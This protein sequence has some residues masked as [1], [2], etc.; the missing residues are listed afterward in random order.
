MNQNLTLISML[1]DRSGSMSAVWAPT[2]DGFNEFVSKQ[3]AEKTGEAS[4]TLIQFDDQYETHYLRLDIKDV[5]PLTTETYAPRGTTSLLDAIGRSITE[6]GKAL[7]A[8][9]EAERPGKVLFVI[10]TDGQE[11]S[12]K[13]FTRAQVFDLIKHQREKYAWDFIFLGANQDA[14]TVGH[15]MGFQGSKTMTFGYNVAG[16]QFAFDSAAAYTTRTRSFA[17]GA[18]GQ[19]MNSFTEE[20]REE[21]TKAGVDPAQNKVV[22]APTKI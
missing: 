5:R 4:M 18:V 13:E 17:T 3:K 12:S 11:N 16:T 1:L 10:I 14:I 6:T 9:P 22:D 2:I 21:Q 20:E 8:M 15:T 19:S 7:A